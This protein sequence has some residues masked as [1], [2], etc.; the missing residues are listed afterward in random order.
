MER[1][2][3]CPAYNNTQITICRYMTGYFQFT[4]SH[5]WSLICFPSMDIILA[6][7]STPIDENSHHTQLN[8]GQLTCMAAPGL[9][10]KGE[11]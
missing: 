5:I 11:G 2:D 9:G 1:K 7:N 4:V 3:S 8:S 10:D 6:P